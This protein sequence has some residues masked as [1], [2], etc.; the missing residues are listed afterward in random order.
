[1]YW[2][3]NPYNHSSTVIG[4]VTSW[5]VMEELLH[6]TGPLKY[7]DVTPYLVNLPSLY[8]S[9]SFDHWKAGILHRG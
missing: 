4:S 2:I 5:L 9:G 3:E 8:N 7:E 1:M 6:L